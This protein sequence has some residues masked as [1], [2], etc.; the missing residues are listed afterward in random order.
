MADA[1]PKLLTKEDSATSVDDGQAG[2]ELEARK[3]GGELESCG[4]LT[5]VGDSSQGSGGIP[6]GFMKG[7]LGGP[8][9]LTHLELEFIIS[10]KK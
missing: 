3:A 6:G 8:V 7:D 4:A 5:V 10:L 1:V 2:G 9:A